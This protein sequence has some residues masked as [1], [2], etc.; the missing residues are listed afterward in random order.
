MVFQLRVIN[1]TLNAL[2]RD[3]TTIGL[4]EDQRIARQ[5]LHEVD[6]TQPADF[7]PG[8]NGSRTNL[9]SKLGLIA[10]SLPKLSN[11]IAAQFFFHTSATQNLTGAFE[12]HESPPSDGPTQTPHPDKDI[13][14]RS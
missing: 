11:A 12:H 3:T 1:E 8:A 10:N 7:E 4:H 14:D 5:L 6:M 13:R 9:Q 2:P